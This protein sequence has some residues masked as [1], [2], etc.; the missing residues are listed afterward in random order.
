MGAFS[1]LRSRV[2][3]LPPPFP[4]SKTLIKPLE[5]R[6]LIKTRGRGYGFRGRGNVRKTGHSAALRGF[7]GYQWKFSTVVVGGVLHEVG[8]GREGGRVRWKEYFRPAKR[9][10]KKETAPVASRKLKPFTHHQHHHHPSSFC[11]LSVWVSHIQRGCTG[12]CAGVCVG[13]PVDSGL[14]LQN[15]PREGRIHDRGN[16][17]RKRSRL[18]SLGVHKR[19]R[20]HSTKCEE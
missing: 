6:N 5:S 13:A 1:S 7:C 4:L 8:K 20:F 2:S 11:H 15:K 3:F 10:L 9:Q 14:I 19:R 18:K 16:G 17:R 12:A